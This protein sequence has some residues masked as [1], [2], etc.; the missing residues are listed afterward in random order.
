MPDFVVRMVCVPDG[1]MANIFVTVGWFPAITEK[2]VGE[3]AKPGRPPEPG[4][5]TNIPETAVVFPAVTEMIVWLFLYPGFSRVI[6]YEPAAI[7]VMV[8]GVRP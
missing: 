8:F 7:L 3:K 2:I 6:V 5:G 1:S 4:S